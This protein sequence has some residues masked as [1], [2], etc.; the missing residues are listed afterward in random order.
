MAM[1]AA[2]ILLVLAGVA[3]VIIASGGEDTPESPRPAAPREVAVRGTPPRAPVARC[4]DSITAAGPSDS[5]VADDAVDNVVGPVRL[6]GL[7]TYTDWAY[8]VREDQWIKTIAVI[9]AGVRVTLEV[10]LEQ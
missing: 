5:I 7:R 3:V 2:A 10:P 9:D 4:R 8:L 1:R 6:S